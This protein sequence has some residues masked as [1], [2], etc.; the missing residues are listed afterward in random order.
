MENVILGFLSESS[1]TPPGKTPKKVKVEVY[2]LS[3]QQ[4][5]LI[6]N[7]KS[8]KKLW[9]EAMG[10]LSLGPVR[11]VVNLVISPKGFQHS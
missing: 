5:A 7:D 2:K 3:Q 1:K 6:K 8:N 4:K 10:S 9:D 11:I